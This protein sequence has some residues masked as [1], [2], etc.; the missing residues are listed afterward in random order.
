MGT[1]RPD[2]PR[3]IGDSEDIRR[4]R[5]AV[6]AR[7]QR[8]AVEA[9][10]DL[11]KIPPA[12]LLSR[13]CPSAF[14][15]VAGETAGAPTLGVLSSRAV[16]SDLISA[17]IDGVRASSQGRP[18]SPHDLEREI[19]WRIE[20]VLA[21]QD[22]NAAVLR[23]E[24]AEV[25]AETDAPR[26]ALSEATETRND[27]LRND[28]ISAIDTLSSGYPE[29]AFLA[30]AGD[31]EA[32]Q[33]QQRLDGQGAEF[34]SL[35]E[36]ADAREDLAAIPRRDSGCPYRGLLPFDQDDAEVFFGRQRLTAELVVK[37]AGRLAG[38]S[39]VV[40]SGASGAGKSSLLRAGL[41]P[42]LAAGVQLESSGWP[43][44]VMT[45]TG[46]PLTELATR[47]ARLSHGDAAAIRHGL[48]ADP[49]RAHLVVG[50]AVL[51]R[52]AGDNGSW[53]P[54]AARPGR[55]VLAVDQFE[56]VFTLAPSRDV[57]QQA[58][59]AA[60]CAAASQPFGPRGEPPAVVVI[61]V[62]GD[63]W[64]R[65]TAQAGLARLMQD[66]MFVVG[67]M[68]GTELRE[69]ITGPAAAARLQVDADLADTI[70]VD[71]RTAGQDEA[72][73]IL[74]LLSQAMMLTWQ[75]RDGNRLTV[76]G[77]H[78][79]GGVARS[80]EFGAE[81]VYEALPDAAQQ[82]A[83]DT[84]RALVLVGP[85]GQLARRAVPRA[86]LA[87]G[88]R[89][90]A[91]RALGTVLEAFA[92]SRLLVLDGDTV[93]IAHDVLLR[94]WPRLRGW[95]DSE[96]ASWILYTQLQ[97]NAAEWAAHG[98]DS[99]FLYRGSQLAAVEQAA[100][101]W[102]ADPARYPALTGDRSGFLEASQR[103]A[104]RSR[105]LRRVLA[106]SL[107]LALAASLAGGTAA[108]LAA[109]KA[110]QQRNTAISSQL[111]AQSEALDIADPV[112]AAQLAGAAWQIAPTSQARDSM[113]DAFAQPDRAVLETDPDAIG[114]EFTP[115]GKTLAVNDGLRVQLWNVATRR[116]T[117]PPIPATNAVSNIKHMM[118]FNPDG[119]L[120]ATHSDSGPAIPNGTAID[121]GAVQ[122]WDVATRRSTGPPINAVSNSAR[123]GVLTGLAFSANG[124]ML[125]TS[126]T[127]GMAR[128]WNVA[129]RHQVGPPIDIPGKA[130]NEG[131][132]DM[133][134]KTL[135]IPGEFLTASLV[136]F[137]PKG[138]LLA[139]GGG[140][141][142]VRLWSVAT[143]DQVGPPIKVASVPI[144]V[145]TVAF[146]PDGRLLVTES[147]NGT[148]QLWDV[149]THH[150]AGPPISV[151]SE[152]GGPGLV[153]F[154]PDGMFLA[155]AGRGGIQ[156]WNVAT[157]E[158]AGPPMEASTEGVNA[159]AFSPDSKVLAAIGGDGTVRLLDVAEYQQI[160]Q[161]IDVG[162]AGA[163]GEAL[164][165]D[166][167]LVAAAGRDRLIRLQNITTQ[168]QVSVQLPPQFNEAS[169]AYPVEGES[170]MN[171]V[172]ASQN[173]ILAVQAQ[174]GL[175]V[176]D[177]STRKRIFYRTGGCGYSKVALSSDGNI[178]AF[179]QFGTYTCDHGTKVL[180]WNLAADRMITS[181][182]IYDGA[183]AEMALSTDGRML[184][185]VDSRDTVRL[186][187]VATGRRYR[188]IPVG[189][190]SGLTFSPDGSLLATA[191]G[192]GT[193]RL[194]DVA[195]QQQVGLSM[196]ASTAEGAN[197][198]AFTPDGSLLATAGGDGTVRLWDVATQQQIGPSIKAGGVS[199]LA[200]SP[201]ATL[202]TTL[203]PNHAVR[204]WDVTF[205]SRL[206]NAMCSI[207][208]HS[209][210]PSEW[211]VHIPSE[212]YRRLCS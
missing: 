81:A 59:I 177:V 180:L 65:C 206:P 75:R 127:D 176:L 27:R 181:I 117:R 159:M 201:D 155:T 190:L 165:A 88:R 107:I 151:I 22:E 160:G 182:N 120:L 101:R 208:G 52:V 114:V 158:Q 185:T 69:A 85:D 141:G 3:L 67:P 123:G 189:T 89:E 56:E 128:L 130:L 76:Q 37:L 212:P 99:S 121:N 83:R 82:T 145:V 202:L 74:P 30:R 199:A 125:A 204:Q 195:T 210:T 44:I 148:V 25:L 192:D 209:L 38:P 63:F 139:T 15:A 187:E 131:L 47:L 1:S 16:L 2:E 166:G 17:A 138:T 122:L 163:E 111:A 13:L 36:S 196:D 157:G 45:P 42:A 153:S 61:A 156:L 92:S 98:R 24:I 149:A 54:A 119:R 167:R 162:A 23:A 116:Q 108:V 48:A 43:R 207:A 58:F 73:G 39:M 175:M 194:W 102:A 28:V 46:D 31:H 35:S 110:G 4:F 105:R 26:S 150:Q 57:G 152:G 11:R 140:D 94:A 62:R 161:G 72:E 5:E 143:H 174:N 7:I 79:S 115:D 186:R 66:G 32:A 100:A 106:V 41:L 118:A 197:A 53:P 164:S 198:V 93:Q 135:N 12:V 178:L 129:T 154:S 55:L 205:P 34:R 33:M 146:S 169:S 40:V 64:A 95:L 8:A 49:D 168:H 60:L 203:G 170:H 191:G 113:L 6:R 137:S 171:M 84:F 70:L 14:S 50:Q 142:T 104:A 126:G 211:K 132:F 71:L 183:V 97:E 112:L 133:S 184:A 136:A 78:E 144:G 193:V 18:P 124:K 96:Q 68:T 29:M 51:D 91:R 87:A 188:G 77:Y 20:H 134:G 200:F 19:Y 9:G 147:G 179:E 173:K 172:F 109:R 90:A 80:V 103:F 21:A 86:E 10:G